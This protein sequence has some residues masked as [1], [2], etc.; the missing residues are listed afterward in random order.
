MAFLFLF[1]FFLCKLREK[2][3]IANKNA[4][5]SSSICFFSIDHESAAFS[6]VFWLVRYIDN[7]V[8]GL[9]VPID[10]GSCWSNGILAANRGG[11]VERLRGHHGHDSRPVFHCSSNYHCQWAPKDLPHHCQCISPTKKPLKKQRFHDR[12]KKNKSKKKIEHFYSQSS[13]FLLICKE[14]M[15]TKTKKPFLKNHHEGFIRVPEKRTGR[16]KKKVLVLLYVALKE[17][18]HKLNLVLVCCIL[19][20]NIFCESF[21]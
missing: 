16:K 20:L 7:G 8:V 11:R 19:A 14:K 13:I 2:Y 21:L 3:W 1:S 18:I 4:Q 17:R 10:N 6:M 15:K 9:W 12:S 5:F